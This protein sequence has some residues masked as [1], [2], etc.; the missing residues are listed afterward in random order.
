M[1]RTTRKKMALPLLMTAALL[2]VST[3]GCRVRQTQE[4]EMPEVQVKGGQ[5]PKYD[6]K[7]PKVDVKT[8]ERQVTVPTEVDVKTQKRTIKVPKVEVKPPAD[9]HKPPQQ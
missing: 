7:G 4:G 3:T 8:E 6:V 9:D 5:V 1:I 2:T